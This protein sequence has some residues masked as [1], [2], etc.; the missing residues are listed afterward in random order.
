MDMTPY[1][2]GLRRDLRLVAESS[3]PEVAAA[4]ERL[5]AAIEPAA[6]LALMEALSHA[7]AEI[8]AAMPAGSVE[9]RLDGRDL[10]FVVDAP[11]APSVQAPAAPAAPGGDV[12]PDDGSVTRLTLRLPDSLKTRAEEL[13]NQ[14]GTSLNAWLVSAVRQATATDTLRV[15]V[16]LSSLPFGAG[17]GKGRRQTGWV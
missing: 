11:P 4:A 9:V 10:D 15:D 6:R 7:A 16:D 3:S 12:D 17:R 14:A 8:T 13:A 2:D 5:G 1:L